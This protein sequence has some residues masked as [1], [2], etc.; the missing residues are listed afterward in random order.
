MELTRIRPKNIEWKEKGKLYSGLS[1]GVFEYALLKSTTENSPCYWNSKGDSNRITVCS[2]SPI[3]A[4]CSAEEAMKKPINYPFTHFPLILEI[5][6]MPYEDSLAARSQGRIVIPRPIS[7]DDITVLFSTRTNAFSTDQRLQKY[8]QGIKYLK[9]FCA[10]YG[11]SK[12]DLTSRHKRNGQQ[13]MFRLL[14][15]LYGMKTRDFAQDEIAKAKH[16][17]QLLEQKLRAH[18]Q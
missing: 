3:D 10:K 17:L 9:D 18:N 13:I 16:A 2:P 6:A 14:P 1:Q 4:V 12:A 15:H 7:L 11:V 8:L 5:N